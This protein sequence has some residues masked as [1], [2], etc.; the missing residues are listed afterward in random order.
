[1]KKE[2][3]VNVVYRYHVR[4]WLCGINGFGIYVFAALMGLSAA[5][6]NIWLATVFGAVAG[7]YWYRVTQ[8]AKRSDD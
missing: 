1:M 6:N 7:F 5:E 4:Q 3:L 2:R 8:D